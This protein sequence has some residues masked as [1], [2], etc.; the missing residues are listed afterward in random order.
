MLVYVGP[1]VLLQKL[2]Y[3]AKENGYAGIEGFAGIP[4]TVGGAIFGN[5]GAFGY[6]IK[7]ILHSVELMDKEG[8]IKRSNQAQSPSATGL[9]RSSP[10]GSSSVQR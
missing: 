8:N 5:S 2:L 7:D 4:G 9:R 3:Y 1:G 6:E 10:D